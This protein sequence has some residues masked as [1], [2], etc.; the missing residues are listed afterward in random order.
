MWYKVV[1]TRD[2]QP[3]MDHSWRKQTVHLTQ[4]INSQ[5]FFSQMEK[6]V[7]PSAVHL[8]RLSGS[9]LCWFCVCYNNFCKCIRTTTLSYPG[10]IISQQSFL[11]S[12]CYKIFCYLLYVPSHLISAPWPVSCLYVN[13]YLLHEE[14]PLM[15]AA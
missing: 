3:I 7:R 10:N 1:C 12:G 8:G 13:S 15:N 14:A 6:I 5:K 2:R 11:I 9:V 4:T